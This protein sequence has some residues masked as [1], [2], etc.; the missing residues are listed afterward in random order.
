MRIISGKYRGQQLISFHADHIRPTT[1]RVKE[2]LFNIIQNEIPEAR[3]LDLFSG[4]GNLGI[5]ALSRGAAEVTFVENHPKS[6]EL[7]RKNLEK[8]K[9]VEPYHLLNKD[10]ISFIQRHSKSVGRATSPATNEPPQPKGPPFDIILIDPPFTKQMA[11]EVMQTLSMSDLFKPTTL[12]AIES[13]KKEKLDLNYPPFICSDQ[14]HF[15]DKI[16]SFFRPQE[17]I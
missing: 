7:I 4:T 9:V 6:L 10:V 8:L 15:G 11:D 5:E 17:N 16:L 1:D 3:V 14:R 13:A 2:S 12:I